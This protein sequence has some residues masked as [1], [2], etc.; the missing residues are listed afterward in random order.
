LV[1]SVSLRNKPNSLPL[2]PLSTKYTFW[3]LFKI[4]N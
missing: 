4:Q 2:K 1:C 3:P